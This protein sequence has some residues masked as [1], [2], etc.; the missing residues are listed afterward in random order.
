MFGDI[1][2]VVDENYNIYAEYQYDIWGNCNIISNINNIANINPIRYRGYYYDNETNLY[3]LNSRYYDSFTHR[4]IS[5]DSIEY[6]DF[7]TL[8]GLNLWT[9]CN[10][11]P[12][13]YVDPDGE[14]PAWWQWLLSGIELVV[15]TALCFVPG[16]Q[17]FGIGLI[18]GGAAS[19][20]ANI[21]D[22][23]G[24]DSK[25]STIIVS[26]LNIV[27][28]TALC[29]TSFAGIGAG[30]IGEGIGSIVGGFISEAFGANF[31][32]GSTI[33]GFAGSIICSAMYKVYDIYKINQIAKQGVVVIGE[34]M[35]R[36][37]DYANKIGAG[38]FKASKLANFTFEKINKK[39][40]SLLTYSNNVTWIRRVIKSRVNIANIGIV[41]TRNERSVFYIMEIINIIKGVLY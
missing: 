3:Y 38:T 23:F 9:Y 24:V 6:M 5:I 32:L 36:V 14:S 19:L 34:G 40:G 8:G 11:N 33:G 25:L 20:T 15:G 12:I 18:S 13:M 30:L 28:G 37:H 16:G 21:L 35:N 39:L 41:A 7:D 2:K 22:A 10:N 26:G 27:A 29:F 31:T 4:F 1:L 17:V